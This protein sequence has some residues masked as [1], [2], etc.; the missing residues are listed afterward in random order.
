MARPSKG[1]VTQ[2]GSKWYVTLQTPAKLVDK[3]GYR[4]RRVALQATTRE[5][6]EL[7]AMKYVIAH[8]S[9]VLKLKG[10]L[11]TIGDERPYVDPATPPFM[12]TGRVRGVEGSFVVKPTVEELIIMDDR[13]NELHRLPNGGRVSLAEAGA[14][15]ERSLPVAKQQEIATA[16]RK[17]GTTFTDLFER[18][19]A[20]Q[21]A[22]KAIRPNT[23]HEFR[24]A[25]ETFSEFVDQRPIKELTR[26]DA[27]AFVIAMMQSP[28]RRVVPADLKRASLRELVQWADKNEAKR[29]SRATVKKA[30]GA[31]NAVFAYGLEHDE[32]GLT[33]PIFSGLVSKEEVRA[34]AKQRGHFSPAQVRAMLAA[35]DKLANREDRLFVSVLAYTGARFDEVRQMKLKTYDG[36]FCFDLLDADPKTVESRRL[37]PVHSELL[38]LDLTEEAWVKSVKRDGSSDAANKRVN[39]WIK[40]VTGD[41]AHSAHWFRHTVITQLETANVSEQFVRQLVGHA[42][43]KD[44][45]SGYSHL[46]KQV[47]ELKAAID[48][49]DYADTDAA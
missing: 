6:A 10:T 13:L 5:Q 19:V 27:E 45:H 14:E 26:A 35:L 17:R 3:V 36:V 21:R 22:K 15:F 48:R 11:P 42:A 37:I 33:K 1:F 4:F 12:M 7:E 39:R 40:A 49:L 16:F 9:L 32:F 28:D 31:C 2:H 38:K 18:Y 41:K 30:I 29:V 47:R 43:R 34:T 8:K 46:S 44:A 20:F 25:A 24:L 23:E